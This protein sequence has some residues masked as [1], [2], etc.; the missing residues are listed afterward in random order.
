MMHHW[1]NHAPFSTPSKWKGH[2]LTYGL[3]VLW[4]WWVYMVF[5]DS[6]FGPYRAL[7][8]RALQQVPQPFDGLI[9]MLVGTA[10]TIAPVFSLLY[11]VLQVSKRRLRNSAAAMQAAREKEN[12]VYEKMLNDMLTE[13]RGNPALTEKDIAD[14]QKSIQD[15]Q[16]E[17]RDIETRMARYRE[18]PQALKAELRLQTAKYEASLRMKKPEK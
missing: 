3:A 11:F 13:A 10:V 15:A 18:N 14:I 5:A 4:F 7:V 16:A 8:K 12:Q 2:L 6:T 1:K 9:W 17:R